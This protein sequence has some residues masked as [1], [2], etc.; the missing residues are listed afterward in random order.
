MASPLLPG[1]EE[2]NLLYNITRENADSNGATVDE[3]TRFVCT[4]SDL[5]DVDGFDEEMELEAAF[6]NFTENLLKQQGRSLLTFDHREIF[7]GSVG[8]V[9]FDRTAHVAVSDPE[10][11]SAELLTGVQEILRD[12]F[13]LWR[14]RFVLDVDDDDIIVYPSGLRFNPRFHASDPATMIAD[15]VRRTAARWEVWRGTGRRQFLWVKKR[16]PESLR[17][18]P[19]QLFEIVAIVEGYQSGYD[20]DCDRWTVYALSD[21]VEPGGLVVERPKEAWSDGEYSILADGSLGLRDEWD[22]QPP[23]L[24]CEVIPR[25]QEDFDLE[26]RAW[27]DGPAQTVRI[28][29]S[30]IVRDEQLLQMEQRGELS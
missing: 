16:L 4:Q 7:N 6:E 26:L 24:Y 19:G 9:T 3:H 11:I 15:W 10:S 5:P 17:R 14:M 30:Q 28:Q 12:Q 25:Q 29:L 13:P 1:P 18:L 2:K 20:L 8:F 23:Q 22:R 27:P 21:Y